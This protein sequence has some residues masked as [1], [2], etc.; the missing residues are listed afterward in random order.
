[1]VLP[2]FSYTLALLDEASSQVTRYLSA[3]E[4]ILPIK[5]S[6]SPSAYFV[7]CGR[8]MGQSIENLINTIQQNVSS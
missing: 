4:R 7:L 5:G 2:S 6:A 3:D 8:G 1:M